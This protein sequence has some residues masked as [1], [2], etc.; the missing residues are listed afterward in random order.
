MTIDMTKSRSSIRNLIDSYGSTTT[1][2][3]MTITKDKWGDKTESDGSDVDTVSIPFDIFSEKFN[4]KQVGDINE[5]DLTLIIK[6]TETIAAESEEIRYK[7][8]FDSIEYDVTSVED[9]D[10]SGITLAKQIIVKKR[11]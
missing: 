1:I 3:P 6:D 5:G 2:T 7:I 4:F 8:T 9:Y 11:D 10:I